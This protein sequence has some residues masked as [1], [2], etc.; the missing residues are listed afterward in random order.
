MMMKETRP[1]LVMLVW[2]DL[3]I[4]DK[5]PATMFLLPAKPRTFHHVTTPQTRLETVLH[6]SQ[7]YKQLFTC[8]YKYELRFHIKLS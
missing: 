8:D 6:I 1:E 7:S 5:T 2:L 3:K 4:N